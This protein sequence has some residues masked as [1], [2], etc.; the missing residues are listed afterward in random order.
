MKFKA[1]TLPHFRR[2]MLNKTLFVMKLT[3][4]LMLVG[5]LQV[6]A[7]G[8]SQEV[9]L[10]EK[11]A[12]LQ[13]ILKKIHKQ[14][15][16]L[17]WYDVKE[18]GEAKPVDIQVERVSIE[19]ALSICFNGQPLSYTI[20]NKTVV[21]KSLSTPPP[22][23]ADPPP[24]PVI[25]PPVD[26]SGKIIDPEGK[27]VPGVSI[28]VKGSNKGTF[29]AAD[30][31]FTLTDVGDNAELEISSVGFTTQTIAVGKR[32]QITISLAFDVREEE[33]VVISY[34]TQKKA[35]LTGAIAT[36]KGEYQAI[37]GNQ[38]FQ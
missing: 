14:T 27:P 7:K 24:T 38:Y 8:L 16:Y 4:F 36:V 15:G 10:S 35:T 31:T 11:G 12:R 13:K 17:F 34:G 21:V 9:S 33:T 1:I 6:A 22:L 28:K 32:K 2:E 29:T 23:A 25:P 19:K 18:I 5:F 37:S 20:I 3:F 26:I 30:G